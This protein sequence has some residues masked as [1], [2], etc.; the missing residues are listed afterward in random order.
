M[1]RA[2]ACTGTC[3][4][5]TTPTSHAC[6][7]RAQPP[8]LS[9]GRWSIPKGEVHKDDYFGAQDIFRG[10]FVVTAPLTLAAGADRNVLLKLKIQ[11]CADAGLCY[12]PQ[13]SD[14]KV[15][16][17]AAPP[18]AGGGIGAILGAHRSAGADRD[19]LPP[20]DAFRLGALADG[21]DRV[22]LVWQIANGYY[23][24]RSRLA[25]RSTNPSVGLGPLELPAGMPKTDEYFGKQE[26]YE[27]E[28]VADVP[29]EPRPRRG[30]RCVPRRDLSGLRRGWALLSA[31]PQNAFTWNFPRAQAPAPVAAPSFPNRIALR[32]SSARA[33]SSSCSAPSLASGSC[34]HSPPA[35]CRWCRYCPE[36]SRARQQRHDRTC[37]FAVAR[38]RARHGNHLHRGRR[39]LCRRRP[40]GAGRVSTALDRGALR[41]CY[42]SR[43]R[44][45]C[46]GSSRCRCRPPFRR[47]LPT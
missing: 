3:L 24:Y 9:S 23:L 32:P 39:A 12:P 5:A 13:L 22:R 25:V 21:P 4:P 35:C 43:L 8:G 15:A 10:A 16:L 27:R 34:S 42:L 1:P 45:R 47:G 37:L 2:S 44:C 29:F 7:C 18:A 36:S 46:S 19:F 31:H 40:A 30:A 28:L 26:T 33:I 20:D 41:R 38:L 14:A 11:G 6:R 17:P